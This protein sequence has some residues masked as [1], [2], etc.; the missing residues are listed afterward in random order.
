MIETETTVAVGEGVGVISCLR[1]KRSALT[2]P[3][4]K[5][6]VFRAMGEPSR[7][8]VAEAL[9]LRQAAP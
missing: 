7:L 4:M 9:D 5:A 2:V 3:F 6:S 8:E 1:G